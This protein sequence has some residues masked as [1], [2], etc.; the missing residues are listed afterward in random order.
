MLES[1][2]GDSAAFQAAED[3]EWS[4]PCRSIFRS[5]GSKEPL[6]LR[7]GKRKSFSVVARQ[8]IHGAGPERGSSGLMKSS[9]ATESPFVDILWNRMSLS[10]DVKRSLVVK[11][12]SNVAGMEQTNTKH[13][14]SC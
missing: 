7:C 9:E 10:L 4:F 2:N 8:G 12:H 3:D 13:G 5:D 14:F 1:L 6:M 11:S